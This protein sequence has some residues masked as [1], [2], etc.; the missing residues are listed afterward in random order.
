M[1]GSL[2][3]SEWMCTDKVNITR[4]LRTL[5]LSC[6]RTAMRFLFPLILVDLR[7][8]AQ[9]SFCPSIHQM[10]QTHPVATSLTP[11]RRRGGTD[12]PAAPSQTGR[13]V[14]RSSHGARKRIRVAVHTLHVRKSGRLLRQSRAERG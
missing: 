11:S 8:A 7:S 2:L 13:I 12:I 1:H 9:T 14:A 10:P 5:S 6:L 3:M 4:A